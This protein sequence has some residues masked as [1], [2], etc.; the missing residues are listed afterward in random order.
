MAIILLNINS[1]SL[2]GHVLLSVLKW[3]WNSQED[4]NNEFNGFWDRFSFKIYFTTNGTDEIVSDAI[5]SLS[6]LLI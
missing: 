5:L 1:R 4:Y 3:E 6:V 2:L